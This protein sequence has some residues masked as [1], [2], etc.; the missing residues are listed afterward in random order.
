MSTIEDLKS[1]LEALEILCAKSTAGNLIVYDIDKLFTHLT[2]EAFI[3][4]AVSTVGNTRSIPTIPT[5]RTDNP[6]GALHEWCAKSGKPLSIAPQDGT[7]G[8]FGCV[9]ECDGFK[10]GGEGSTKKYAKRLACQLMLD[11][12]AKRYGAERS[13]GATSR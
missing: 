3:T 13:D 5:H 10:T 4:R 2:D 12:L 11:S 7:L 6:V 1:H 8:K 9:V